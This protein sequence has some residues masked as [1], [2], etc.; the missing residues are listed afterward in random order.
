MAIPNYFQRNAVAISQAISGLDEQR[1]ESMLGDVCIGVTVGPDAGG[2]EGRA[3]VDLLVRLLAR[4]YPSIVILDEGDDGVADEVSALAGRINPRIELSGQP[5]VEV[6]IGSAE[7]RQGAS[8]TVFVGSRGWSAKLSTR[9][10]QECGTTNNPYGAGLAACLAAADLFRSVFLTGAELD[11]DFE[12]AFPTLTKGTNDVGDISGNVG[13]LV[14][15]GAGAIGN[16][17]AWALSR[18]R[19]KRVN[20]DRRS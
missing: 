14:L 13:S 9:N 17:A 3:T 1:L 5:T 4:L 12:F 8:R 11:G 16:A 15:A 20:R 18:N 6:V 2:H 10:P 7:V 19:R